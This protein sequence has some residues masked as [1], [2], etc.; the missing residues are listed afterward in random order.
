[1]KH[2]GPE[3][4]KTLDGL[5]AEVRAHGL[6][7]PRPGVFY[8]Q[9]KAWLHFHEDPAGL[10]ADLREGGDWRRVDV[11]KAAGRTRLLAM[12]TRGLRA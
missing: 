8:L 9:G 11:S 2:A 7:E 3:A 4:L 12:I 10:F 6:R 5:L 1:M